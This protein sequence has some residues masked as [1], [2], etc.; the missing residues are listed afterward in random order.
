MSSIVIFFANDHHLADAHGHI[1][2]VLVFN[3]HDILSL[4]ARHTSTSDFTQKSHSIAYLH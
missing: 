3:E 1:E 4:E 2:A